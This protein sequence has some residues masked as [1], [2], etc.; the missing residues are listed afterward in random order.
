MRER[1]R[2]GRKRRKRKSRKEGSPV[3]TSLFFP[4]RWVLLAL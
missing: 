3:A 4:D 1:R 2:E